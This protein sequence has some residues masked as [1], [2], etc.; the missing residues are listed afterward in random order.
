MIAVILAT[1]PS[2]SQAVA[3]SVKGQ[4]V[5]VV[6]DA[7]RLAPWADVLVATDGKWWRHNPDALEFK[8]R[9]FGVSLDH[10]KQFAEVERFSGAT[11][12]NSGLLAC[13]V[14]VSLGAKK[15]LLAGFDMGGTHFFGPHREPL[16]NTTKAR[17]EVFKRQF[18][19]YQPRGVKILNCTPNSALRCYP[20]GSLESLAESPLHAA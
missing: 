1:G 7:F 12:T 14:A 17:F 11:G 15:L 8:G 3:D 6:S 10:H 4:F 2:M 19:N 16:K 18:A 9:K 13:Q 20:M 5:I